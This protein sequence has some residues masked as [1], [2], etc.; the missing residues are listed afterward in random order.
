MP[1]RRRLAPAAGRRPTPKP[2][3][4]TMNAD[5][6]DR[7]WRRA[8][9]CRAGSRGGGQ[10]AA[11]AADQFEAAATA[12]IPPTPRKR[13]RGISCA[14]MCTGV[15]QECTWRFVH[16]CKVAWKSVHT[17]VHTGV[18]NECTQECTR[19]EHRSAHRS[20]L[21]A[22]RRTYRRAALQLG[23]APSHL[24]IFGRLGSRAPRGPGPGRPG[25]PIRQLDK[26]LRYI[27]TI[28]LIGV[29]DA[30]APGTGQEAS[31]TESKVVTESD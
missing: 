10:R 2:F 23:K 25:P 6:G 17:G 16:S 9:A 18:H 14:H 7:G 1:L 13:H 19:S 30:A 3:R 15:H 22:A 31:L 8:A 20:A 11:A 26:L 29:P 28:Y 4:R 21:A 27:P 5:G 24:Y 12:A